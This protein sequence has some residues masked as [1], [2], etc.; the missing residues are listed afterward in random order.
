MIA[1]YLLHAH[2]DRSQE[3]SAERIHD[4]PYRVVSSP[5]FLFFED[6]SKRIAQN[7]TYLD[8]TPVSD[9]GMIPRYDIFVALW[10]KYERIKGI[11]RAFQGDSDFCCPDWCSLWPNAHFP[12]IRIAP[13]FVR[14]TFTQ[15]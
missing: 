2:L 15:T 8:I 6:I 3:R 11:G 1:P 14:V 13:I 10:V 5:N 7:V 9:R 12:L 4:R